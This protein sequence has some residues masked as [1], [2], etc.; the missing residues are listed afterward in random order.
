MDQKDFDKIISQLREKLVDKEI[1]IPYYFQVDSKG[2]LDRECHNCGYFFKISADAWESLNNTQ[3]CPLCKSQGGKE[4]FYT[5]E[6][7]LKKK[8]QFDLG[9]QETLGDEVTT[10]LDDLYSRKDIQNPYQ[11]E[12]FPFP[13][14]ITP[15]RVK[16]VSQIEI[17]CDNC[18]V[19]YAIYGSAYFCPN[20][21]HHSYQKI[22][23]NSVAKI[24]SKLDLA[25][26]LISKDTV[27]D[28]TSIIIA[29]SLIE[30]SL[31]DCVITFQF[32]MEGIFKSR[33]PTI[34]IPFNIFQRIDDG[35]Q[36]WKQHQSKGY[37]DILAHPELDRIKLY[38]Q[39][40]HLLSHT[41]GIVDA[42]YLTKSNDSFYTVGQRIVIKISEVE[43]CLSFIEKISNQI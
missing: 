32:N 8:E 39:R 34:S 7:I 12:G 38:F 30:T 22:F 23:Q 15:E 10:L 9:M 37:E 27:A 36:F 1:K 13:N 2:F 3:F 29:R 41:D 6:Q 31:N 18:S 14:N 28:D 17:F 35:N 4:T 5:E 16:E 24:K 42:K 43:E 21:G 19:K 20:C 33:F 40:R 26:T 25:D 11:I